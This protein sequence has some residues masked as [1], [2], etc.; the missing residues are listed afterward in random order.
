M[1]VSLDS[2]PKMAAPGQMGSA[3]AAGADLQDVV[4]VPARTDLMRG[5]FESTYMDEIDA[6]V[7][8]MNNEIADA[9]GEN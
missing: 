7:D 1:A 6:L 8:K 3:M 4:N 5:R 2:C 9:I